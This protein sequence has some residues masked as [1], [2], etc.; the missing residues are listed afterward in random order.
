MPTSSEYAEQIETIRDFDPRKFALGPAEEMPRS[1][2]QMEFVCRLVD[3]N[4]PTRDK[5]TLKSEDGEEFIDAECQFKNDLLK[6]KFLLDDLVKSKFNFL[7]NS[8]FWF[9][10]NLYFFV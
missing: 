6:Q 5:D 8:Q 1:L 2:D 7:T 10:Q 3:S 9:I 4:K